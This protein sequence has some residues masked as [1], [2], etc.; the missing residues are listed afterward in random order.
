M[1]QAIK[2]VLAKNFTIQVEQ[3]SPDIAAHELT[4]E[5]GIFD[6]SFDSRYL[7]SKADNPQLIDPL[8]FD[9]PESFTLEDDTSINWF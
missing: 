4:A 3:I 5:K 9:A 1:S 8:N 6:P 7:R 2:L